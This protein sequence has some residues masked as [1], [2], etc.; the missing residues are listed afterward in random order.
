MAE[1][2]ERFIQSMRM[3]LAEIVDAETAST[4]LDVMCYELKD[5]ELT[6][7]STEI[8]PYEGDNVKVIKSY[9]ACIIVE[10]KAKSTAKQ[11]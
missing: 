11:Y 5:Y 1:N 9:M 8:V 6:K 4:I 10:G 2:G 7:K 3:R